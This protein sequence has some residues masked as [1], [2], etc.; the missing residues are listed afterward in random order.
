[1]VLQLHNT[2]RNNDP[3]LLKLQDINMA[4]FLILKFHLV[5][6]GGIGVAVGAWRKSEVK[7][8]EGTKKNLV[9]VRIGRATAAT[10]DEQES[11]TGRG[12]W[13]RGVGF[14]YFSFLFILHRYIFS[15]FPQGNLGTYLAF[16]TYKIYS[17]LVIYFIF[18]TLIIYF[19]VVR[20]RV[21]IKICYQ[22]KDVETNVIIKRD[23][24]TIKSK[25][26]WNAIEQTDD[27]KQS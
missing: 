8:D 5:T 23:E 13:K 24:M 6:E 16:Q 15:F 27:V 2:L 19:D 14:T 21:R 4:R 9:A 18:P 1:M 26:M 12:G 11:K 25:S 3:K 22:S 20:L 7:R 17:Y 10:T